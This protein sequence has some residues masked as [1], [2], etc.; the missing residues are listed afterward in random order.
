MAIEFRYAQFSDYPR[1]S[2]FFDQHWEKNYIYVRVPELFNWTFGRT[3][4]WDDKGYSFALIENKGE[5]VGI[6]GAIPFVFNCMGQH[7]PAVWFANYMVHPEYRRG[8]LAMQLLGVFN[9]PPYRIKV[10]FGM[11]SRVVPIYQRM[12]WSTLQ[13]IPRHFVILPHAVDRACNLLHS[14][15]PHWDSTHIEELARYFTLNDI[16][17]IAVPFVRALPP[18]WDIYDWPKI[19]SRTAGAARDLNYL[20]WRYLK[21]PC[22]KYHTVAV[23]EGER[24]GLVVWRLETI[25]RATPHGRE[26]VD[27]IGRLVEFLPV[28]RS[29][30]RNLLS[31]F[32][33]DIKSANALGADFYGFHGESGGW[34]EELGFRRTE[35]HS[36]GESIPAR[37]Q[38]LDSRPSQILSAFLFEGQLPPCS[39]D[40]QCQWYWTKSDADQDRPN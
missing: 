30:A 31:V 29:N 1:I 37:F 5:L 18:N 36:E 25:R 7:F 24:T 15:Q 12:G 34:L 38:P 27:K 13:S 39:S 3:D 6:L 26:E 23:A 16:P 19:A 20:T 35:K 33:N 21:H 9:R 32:F 8:P 10:V 40:Q 17:P 14:A 22:F 11:N 28:S 2:R 4:L